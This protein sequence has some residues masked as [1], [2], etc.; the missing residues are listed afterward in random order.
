MLIVLQGGAERC[1]VAVDASRDNASTTRGVHHSS[2]CRH[3]HVVGPRHRPGRA[4]AGARRPW[5]GH[6]LWGSA[7]LPG[8]WR[9]AERRSVTHGHVDQHGLHHHQRHQLQTRTTAARFVFDR[10]T[11][12]SQ[13]RM[14][15]SLVSATYYFRRVNGVNGGDNAFIGCVSVCVCAQRTLNVDSSKTVRDT[16]FKFDTHVERTVRTWPI[17]IFRKGDVAKVTWPRNLWT[18]HDANWKKG[19]S[20]GLQIWHTSALSYYCVLHHLVGIAYALSRAPS[21]C[22]QRFF[23]TFTSAFSQQSTNWKSLSTKVCDAGAEITSCATSGTAAHW[24]LATSFCC[25]YS[26]A[27]P[28][29]WSC[30]SVMYW[31]RYLLA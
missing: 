7:A 20:H 5:P 14:F 19:W 9:T 25:Q 23:H 6:G 18:L 30:K 3:V 12:T 22:V 13:L 16:D 2:F 28:W 15:D 11:V 8:T 31:L 1:L 27:V 24:G 26:A 21:S 29:T 17:T 4:A 10:I